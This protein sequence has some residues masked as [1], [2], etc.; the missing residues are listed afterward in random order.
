MVAE[1]VLNGSADAP[2][3]LAAEQASMLTFAGAVTVGAVVSS[4]VIVRWTVVVLV[5][6]SATVNMRVI[7]VGHVPAWLS[8]Y[9]IAAMEQLSVAVPPSAWN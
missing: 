9:E 6:W 5:H 8:M 7:T 1:V 4:T 2:E 3:M